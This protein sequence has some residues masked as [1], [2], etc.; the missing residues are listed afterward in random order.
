MGGLD[1]SNQAIARLICSGLARYEQGEAREQSVVLLLMALGVTHE[2]SGGWW[3]SLRRSV[4]SDPSHASV[5]IAACQ[6]LGR[7]RA[8][9]ARDA[10]T[11]LGKQ[12]DPAVKR[13]ALHALELI[14]GSP[15]ASSHR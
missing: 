5:R 9:E 2:E 6:A 13:A 12:A 8:Q 7:L 10:L 15:D 14:S 11:G 1:D 3:S 4:K